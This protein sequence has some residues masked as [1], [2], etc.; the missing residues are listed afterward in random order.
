ME[1]K[2]N[3][4]TRSPGGLADGRADTQELVVWALL[5]ASLGPA[6]LNQAGH[7]RVLTT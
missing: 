7:S 1:A 6:H 2:A 5:R 4:G 3:H